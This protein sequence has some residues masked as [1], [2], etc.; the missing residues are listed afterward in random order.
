MPEG[1]KRLNNQFTAL[2]NDARLIAPLH[3]GLFDDAL[4][5]P[6]LRTADG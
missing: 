4:T 5:R 2:K 1:G 6:R 3:G